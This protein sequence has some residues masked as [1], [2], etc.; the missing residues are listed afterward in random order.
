MTILARKG[1]FV[2]G[3][4][5]L[6]L[7]WLAVAAPAAGAAPDPRIFVTPEV[8]ARVRAALSAPA[9]AAVSGSAA[10]SWEAVRRR[11]DQL[12][13]APPYRYQ[14]D[15]PGREGGPS[16]SWSY[17]LSD[18]PPPRHDDSPHYPVWTAMF[19]ERADSITTRLQH[20]LIAWRISGELRYFEKAREIVWHLASWPGIWTDPSYGGGRPSLDT[21]HAAVWVGVFYDWCRDPLSA[22]ERA[23][24]R[25][26]LAEKALA[27]LSA[28]VGQLDSY[29]N[30][31]AVA[32]TGLGIGAV[33]LLGDDPRAEAWL[34]QAVAKARGYLDAQDPDGAPLEGAVYG[35]YATDNLADLLWALDTAGV[36]HDL[37]THPFL[38][39]LPRYCV[40]LLDPGTGTQPTFGDGNPTPGFGR[41]LTMLALRGDTAAAWYGDR[42]GALG[43]PSPRNLLVL[44]PA[45]LRIAP[46][47]FRPS[48]AFPSAGYAVLRDGYREDGPFLAFKAGPRDRVVG[49][50][51]FDHNSFQL[52]YGGEWIA[53][54]PGSRTYFEP[55]ERRYSV[56]TLGH[57]TAV[58]DLDAP[59]LKSHAIST[60]GRDQVH[61]DRARIAAFFGGEDFDYVRGEAAESYNPDGVRVLE[62]FTREIVFAKPGVFFVR[63]TLEAP[64][65]R[66]YSLLFHLP[67]GGT[68]ELG[69][70]AARAVGRR[71]LLE[72]HPFSPGGVSL[73]AASYPGAERR[74]PYLAATTGRARRAWVTT[75]LVPRR[76][77]R[78]L[79]NPGFED[80]LAGWQIRNAQGQGP[81]HVLDTAVRRGG[82]A[83]ARID[84]A[85]YYYSS[86]FALPAGTRVTARF[87]GRSTAPT[88]ASSVFFFWKGGKA[89]ARTQGPG[90]TAPEWARYEVTATVPEG[91]EQ[92]SLALQ[93]FG[94]GQCWFD[95][96]EVRAEPGPA[97]VEAARVVPLGGAGGQGG[98]VAEVD[99]VTYLL[100]W[101]EAG[102]QRSV[103]AAGRRFATDAEIAAVTLGANGAAAFLV[104]GTRVEMDGVP[105]PRAPGEWVLSETL[106]RPP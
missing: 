18:A 4:V 100:L 83:S 26:A 38:R 81:N 67:Q 40:S 69:G 43:E 103:E 102:V 54:D 97:S 60:P 85:G 46:P 91:T 17:T 35:T 105:V 24:V 88:G 93:F 78:L 62:R 92:I 47:P 16:K 2:G 21:G 96:V 41:I 77:A 82:R 66:A 86:R 76:H 50:N 79:A 45:R 31:A 49:H 58:L 23:R 34:D 84:G 25:A 37:W 20:F 52:S 7:A 8:L 27:P 48:G 74:G 1:R 70:G 30:F 80:G 32:A 99:G 64:E 6:A 19:Q 94:Q 61:L 29:H 101:G 73:S 65:P 9:A 89:F 72:I 87:W 39:S 63:D 51:H 10:Q 42:I 53:S 104:R 3:A 59:Y 55:A 44:D 14:V 75:V 56:G 68:F 11:A 15:I 106:P 12:A 90:P 22:A 28:R 5:L 95:E 71:S 98:A 36:P 33:A 13:A 57:N